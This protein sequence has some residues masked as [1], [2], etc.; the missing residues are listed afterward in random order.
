KYTEYYGL[1]FNI[2]PNVDIYNKHFK[3]DNDEE[4]IER[5]YK[6][7][8]EYIAKTQVSDFVENNLPSFFTT[9]T[10]DKETFA[11]I[12][13]NSRGSFVNV[14]S[15]ALFYRQLC[16]YTLDDYEYKCIKKGVVIFEKK[17][18]SNYVF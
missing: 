4:Q 16:I 11:K 3:P 18:S 2:V 13:R 8:N 12:E 15:L 7:Y 5:T 6:L 14:N 9:G 17:N 1:T 10:Y